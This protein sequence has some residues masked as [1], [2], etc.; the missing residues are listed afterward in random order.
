M[1][2]AQE[3]EIPVTHMR[4]QLFLQIRAY[5]LPSD[6]EKMSCI[7]SNYMRKTEDERNFHLLIPL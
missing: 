3:L 4:T 5:D 6:M 1:L 7:S 2:K